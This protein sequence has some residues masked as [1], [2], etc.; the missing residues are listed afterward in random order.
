MRH[1]LLNIKFWFTMLFSFIVS[2]F[3]IYA[4]SQ[5]AYCAE[6]QNLHK[7]TASVSQNSPKFCGQLQIKDNNNNV[8]DSLNVSNKTND[9]S[10]KDMKS[11]N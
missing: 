4:I 11:I 8:V 9:V 3:I 10:T 7:V 5:K 1:L 2:G 6:P